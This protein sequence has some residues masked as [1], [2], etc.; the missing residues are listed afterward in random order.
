MRASTSF[1]AF[2]GDLGAAIVAQ[3]YRSVNY[4][5]EL[6]NIASLETLFLHHKDKTKIVNIIHQGCRYQLDPIEEET[7]K[8]DLDAMILRV[9]H[10][11]SH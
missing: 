9:N 5:P 2:K 10:K 8:Y 6:G 4:R 1:V 7:Q 3:K 11:S